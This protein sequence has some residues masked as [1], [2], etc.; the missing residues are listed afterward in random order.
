MNSNDSNFDAMSP[1]ELQKESE[2]I[3]KN[4]R[5]TKKTKEMKENLKWINNNFYWAYNQKED[6]KSRLKSAERALKYIRKLKIQMFSRGKDLFS[7]V[8]GV[9]YD[10]EYNKTSVK[11]YTK[12]DFVA[13]IK[14]MEEYLKYIK[15]LLKRKI[16]NKSNKKANQNMQSEQTN[17]TRNNNLVG[18][19]QTNITRNN[20]LVGENEY[21]TKSSL[22]EAMSPKELK[23]ESEEIIKNIRETEKTKKMK[24]DLKWINNGFYWAY[25]QTEDDKS[26]LKS[27]ERALKDIRKL[28]IQMLFRGK[29]LFSEVKNADYD[30]EYNKTSIKYYTKKDF[31]AIIKVMEEYL[32]Y[33]KNILKRKIKNKSN[34]KANQ[35]MQSEQTNITRN[36]NLVGVVGENEYQTKSSL[37]NDDYDIEERRKSYQ[38]T[39]SRRDDPLFS[40]DYEYR[41][42]KTDI[43]DY[44]TQT[45]T[46]QA[47][48]SDSLFNEDYENNR[49]YQNT[50]QSSINQNNQYRN[51]SYPYSD[52][53]Y[54]EERQTSNQNNQYRNNPHPYSD[55]YYEDERQTSNQNDEYRNNP[56]PYRSSYYEDER[57]TSNQNDEYRNNPQ[58]YRSTYN[59]DER[60]ASNQNDEYKNNSRKYSESY[61][62]EERRNNSDYDQDTYSRNQNQELSRMVS[63]DVF[64]YDPIV[65]DTDF[66]YSKSEGKNYKYYYKLFLDEVNSILTCPYEEL[67]DLMK[68][69][70]YNAAKAISLYVGS[71]DIYR[72]EGINFEMLSS[73]YNKAYMIYAREVSIRQNKGE[74]D[75]GYKP[76]DYTESRMKNLANI[77]IK[78]DILEN[79]Y[80]YDDEDIRTQTRISMQTSMMSYEQISYIY[81]QIKDKLDERH[82]VYDKKALQANFVDVIY[83]KMLK[84]KDVS[85]NTMLTDEI[86]RIICIDYL[87]DEK[88]YNNGND[89]YNSNKY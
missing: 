2:E 59:E 70:K 74:D 36:N 39:P 78:D 54:E 25:N 38:T 15:S 68:D 82:A 24:E 34:K 14:K 43:S 21:Q 72:D 19:E 35:N 69:I 47:S 23:E 30:E 63:N 33:I 40:E 89:P 84:L 79:Y 73:L 3:I 4:I 87:N 1:E 20:N 22:Y 65:T 29:Y 17:I 6:D 18:A 48:E 51:N 42:R 28:K 27:A 56:Q 46:Y 76:S 8:K 12:T 7:E 13:I 71:F 81:H 50:Q 52:S 37:Y 85:D 64:D 53:Y 10:D 55:S 32:K 80:G 75:R 61:Y 45:H 67:D 60:Q 41:P 31:V 11:Y 77:Y 57:Q 49:Q 26:R 66:N 62:E 44:P 9:D 58:P 88:D 86:Y 83:R 16:K 5:E